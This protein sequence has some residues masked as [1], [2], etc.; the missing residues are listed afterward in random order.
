M[1]STN[2]IIKSKIEDPLLSIVIPTYKRVNGAISAIKSVLVNTDIVYEIVVIN[3][4]PL[5]DNAIEKFVKNKGS[6]IS[7][8]INK[9]LGM[10]GNW[11][12]GISLAKGKYITI[13]HDDDT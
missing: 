10:F 9:N 2:E 1:S 8:Y 4:D 7:Y 6:N 3:N 5:T 11:N 13:L 12:K